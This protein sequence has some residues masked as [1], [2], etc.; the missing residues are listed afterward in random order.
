MSR[1]L[2]QSTMIAMAQ[3]P[4]IE[5]FMQ[6]ACTTSFRRDDMEMWQK[7]NVTAFL[8]NGIAATHPDIIGAPYRD[9]G[10]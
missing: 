3:S 6:T 5:H 9:K 10:D 1:H 8:M 2:W 7:L 4:C